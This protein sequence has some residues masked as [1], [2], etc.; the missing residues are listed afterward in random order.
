MKWEGSAGDSLG[1]DR[2]CYHIERQL[3]SVADGDLPRDMST[4][5]NVHSRCFGVNCNPV[6]PQ[7]PSDAS[8]IQARVRQRRLASVIPKRIQN[9]SII[10]RVQ[11][12]RQEGKGILE[13][14]PISI[15]KLTLPLPVAAYSMQVMHLLREVVQIRASLAR[16]GGDADIC[17]ACFTRSIL[18][19][20]RF[21]L[22][23]RRH[24]PLVLVIQQL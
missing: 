19:H 24:L 14:L 11:S 6:T 1:Q 20:N 12:K 7:M 10:T 5:R 4:E 15:N 17:M 9:R 13:D 3:E 18:T 2:G 22:Q 21:Y 16:L 8:L 23:R